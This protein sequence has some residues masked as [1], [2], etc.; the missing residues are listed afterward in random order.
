MWTYG[1]RVLLFGPLLSIQM[2]ICG[3]GFWTNVFP[4]ASSRA[5]SSV[6]LRVEERVVGAKNCSANANGLPCCSEKK[7]IITPL[8]SFSLRYVLRSLITTNSM[9]YPRKKITSLLISGIR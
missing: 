7:A 2:K 4:V 1:V 6:R 3:F 9:P 5:P 8:L